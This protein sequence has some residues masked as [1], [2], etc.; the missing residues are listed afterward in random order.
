MYMA[1]QYFN[2]RKLANVGVVEQG[3]FVG[4]KVRNYEFEG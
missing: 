2:Y 3:S 4:N 1:Y